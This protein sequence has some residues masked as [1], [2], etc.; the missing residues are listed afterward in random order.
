MIL[1]STVDIDFGETALDWARQKLGA[2]LIC[3]LKVYASQ[4]CAL[5]AR[6]LQGRHGFELVIV[7]DHLMP[8]EY[9]W[10]ASY[11]G[12]HAWSPGA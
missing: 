6:R 4:L 5:E 10:S 8:G 11:L 12:R 7:P 9:A 3:H 1:K 2:D